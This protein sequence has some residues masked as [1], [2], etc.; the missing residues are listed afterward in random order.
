MVKGISTS[1]IVEDA[2]FVELEGL[3]I[4]LAMVEIGETNKA[5]QGE[6]SPCCNTLETVHLNRRT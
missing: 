6:F 2:R 1:R 4:S 5:T 3:L